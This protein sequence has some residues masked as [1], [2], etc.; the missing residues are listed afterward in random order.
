MIVG[1]VLWGVRER[2]KEIAKFVLVSEPDQSQL[3]KNASDERKETQQKS[4]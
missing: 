4:A 1:N 3:Q 2:E